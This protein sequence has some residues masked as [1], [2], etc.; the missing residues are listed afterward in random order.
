VQL[1]LQIFKVPVPHPMLLLSAAQASSCRI[2]PPLY[3]TISLPA[4]LSPSDYLDNPTPLPLHEEFGRLLDSLLKSSIKFFP[5]PDPVRNPEEWRHTSRTH[6]LSGEWR[7]SEPAFTPLTICRWQF[8]DLLV[9]EETDAL[10][11]RHIV[12]LKTMSRVDIAT[13]GDG[14]ADFAGGDADARQIGCTLGDHTRQMAV[15]LMALQVSFELILIGVMFGGGS[16]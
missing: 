7:P 12:E 1:K 16:G 14:V 11:G 5:G 2:S 13:S 15:S 3:A 10:F 8:G 4:A 6:V 9:C